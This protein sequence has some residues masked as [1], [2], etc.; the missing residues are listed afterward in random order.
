MRIKVYS[1]LFGLVAAGFTQFPG[2]KCQDQAW[3]GRKDKR[4]SPAAD[5]DTSNLAPNDKANQDSDQLTYTPPA[6]N[7]RAHGAFE[8]VTHEGCTGRKIT[9]PANAQNHASEK[10]RD[11]AGCQRRK[12]CG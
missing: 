9:C 12:G 3:N 6:H 5:E 11:E 8:V 1:F 4:Q 2:H 7:A 10:E